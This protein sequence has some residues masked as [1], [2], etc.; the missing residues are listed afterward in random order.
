MSS[1][2]R[3]MISIGYLRISVVEEKI[4]ENMNKRISTNLWNPNF[5]GIILSDTAS[6]IF[7]ENASVKPEGENKFNCSTSRS[8][9][10]EAVKSGNN[11]IN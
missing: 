5:S 10:L 3:N 9:V 2:A 8:M 1:F 11:N 6:S 7:P 4:R